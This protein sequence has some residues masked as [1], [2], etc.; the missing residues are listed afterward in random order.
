MRQIVIGAWLLTTAVAAFA[1][2]GERFTT[3]E[4]DAAGVG[5]D[6]TSGKSHAPPEG[7]SS[8]GGSDDAGTGGRANGSW[9]GSGGT[10]SGGAANAGR[11]GSGG[12]DSG[13][14]TASCTDG[15]TVRMIPSPDLPADYLCDA[16]CGTGWLTITDELG[17]AAFTLFSACGSM[18]CESCSLLPCAAADCVPTPLAAG[19][20]K[21][22][23]SGQ[24][25]AQDTCGA[26]MMACQRPECAPPGKYKARACAAVN[27]G[28]N[29]AVAGSCTP[30]DMQL[31]AEAEFELPG[32]K[33]VVLVLQK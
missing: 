4:D 6:A 15:V 23:W 19:G 20:T 25:L 21:L 31:C 28:A 3:S 16:S 27:A 33:E 7:P 22:S 30:K 17:A 1:C 10:A 9:G 26:K 2:G 18:S 5:N 24:Y 11:P 29:A 32:T 13:G 14:T 12:Q 8:E